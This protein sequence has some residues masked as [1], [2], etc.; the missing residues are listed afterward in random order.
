MASRGRKPNKGEMKSFN[1][2][3]PLRLYGFLGYLVEHNGLG[4]SESE[5]ASYFLRA[6]L[7]E[8]AERKFHELEL[9]AP[10]SD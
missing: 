8:L 6:K 7:I 2:S 1:V 4:G 3:L 9:P 10:Q 5:L